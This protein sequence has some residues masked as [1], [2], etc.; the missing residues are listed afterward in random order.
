MK[1]EKLVVSSIFDVYGEL[2]LVKTYNKGTLRTKDG[3]IY[4][5]WD[6]NKIDIYSGNFSFEITTPE[7][8]K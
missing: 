1:F 5:Y 4:V 6:S 7:V 3:L 8:K 2:T